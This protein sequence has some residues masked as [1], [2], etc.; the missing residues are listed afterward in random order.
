MKG[1]LHQDNV[2]IV[3]YPFFQ[4]KK[5]YLNLRGGSGSSKSW[6]AG[7]K[8]LSWCLNPYGHKERILVLRKVGTTLRGSVFAML[9]DQ[10]KLY[11][12]DIQPKF[13]TLSFH[14]P[15]GNDIILAGLDDSEKIKSI[16]G[17]T[18]IWMEEAT[19]FTEQ[20][21]EQLDLRLR[22]YCDSYFQ[23]LLSF[24]PIHEMHWLR[25]RFWLSKEEYINVGGKKIYGQFDENV[26]YNLVTTYKD[27]KFVDD[28]YKYKMESI[29]KNH[30]NYRIYTLGEWGIEQNDNMWLYSFQ[31]D[32][33]IINKNLFQPIYEVYLSFDFNKDPLTCIAFQMSPN[34]GD[35]NSFIYAI[36]EFGGNVS[37]KD[38]CF[39]IKSAFPNSIL[40]V[41]GDRSG[42]TEG[43]VGYNSI[44]DTAYSLIK[45]H[46]GLN[47]NNMHPNTHNLWYE[48]SR[49][50]INTMLEL[51]P[52]I[53]ISQPNCPNLINDCLI[54]TIDERSDKP[55]T[56]KKDREVYKMDYFDGF[57]YFFQRYFQQYADSVYFNLKNVKQ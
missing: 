19:E 5:R 6:T 10:I 17:I 49:M 37:V 23:I 42:N 12:L 33:H 31:F 8:I 47:E 15:N 51:Y 48:N 21:F 24:N 32:K 14:A 40:F 34:K 41:T 18:K 38:L 2:N 11:N 36:R 50:L 52:N 16:A 1:L 7:Q 4:S 9:L 30:P 55:H 22:G 57:R 54:A 45:T 46:L 56:L 35:Y 53:L 26:M 29:P 20:D 39:Q 27:N 44:H 13:S 3:Y 43:V 28:A 25:R